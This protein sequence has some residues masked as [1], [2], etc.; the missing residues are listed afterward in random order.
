MTGLGFKV[1]RVLKVACPLAASNCTCMSAY[2]VSSVLI[3]G[4]LYDNY[5]RNLE[6]YC[7]CF[8]KALYCCLLDGVS[9]GRVMKTYAT[10]HETPFN[11]YT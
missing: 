4:T 8:L 7:W 2:H 9:L 6:A 11:P 3:R 5:I 10:S 1:S